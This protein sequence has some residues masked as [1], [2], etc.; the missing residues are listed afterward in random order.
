[1]FSLTFPVWHKHIQM[2]YYKKVPLFSGGAGIP[3]D[4]WDIIVCTDFIIQSVIS[5]TPGCMSSPRCTDL[6]RTATLNILLFQISWTVATD[7]ELM[8]VIYNKIL[9]GY[10][11]SATQT[12]VVLFSFTII[13]SSWLPILIYKIMRSKIHRVCRGN[14]FL[15]LQWNYLRLWP[16]S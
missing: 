15:Q 5:I 10:F 7:S 8:A 9:L 14:L 6:I 11:Y 12:S 3:E 13:N 2:S 4:V 16:L 1:M